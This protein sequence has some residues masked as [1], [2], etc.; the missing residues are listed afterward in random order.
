MVEYNPQE[1]EKRILD[2]WGKNK[3]FDKLMK[4]KKG[5]TFSF[6]DGPPTANNPMG[7][8]HAWGRTYKD[9][10]LR[11]KGMQGFETRRQP[12]FDCQ[13]LWVE[14]GVEK[15]LDFKTKKDIENYGIDKFTEKCKESVLK[16]VKTWIELSKK[17]G[18][19]MDWGNAYLTMSDT[20]IEY[21]WYFLK[22]CYEKGWLYKGLR[23]LPWCPRCQTSLSSHEVAS[24][25]KEKV[26][27]AIYVKF[28]I[29]DR[30]AE[31][32]LIYTTTPW[33]L[34]SN[35]AVAAHPDIEYVRIKVGEEV[36][37]LAK[38]LLEKAVLEKNYS[39]LQTMYGRELVEIQYE[40]P[41]KDLLPLQWNI[42]GKVVLSDKYV[43]AEEGT[44]LV[45]IAPGHGPE[46]YEIGKE[47]KLPVLSPLNEAGIFNEEVGFLKGKNAKEANE[48]VLEKLKERGLLY[49]EEKIKHSYPCCWRCDEE[50][51]YRIGEE[52]FISTQEIKPKLL[53]E[54]K[55]V[56]WYP[57]WA[58]KSMVDW[59]TNLK[60][61]N[62]SRKRYYGLPLPFWICEKCGLMDVIESK[63]ELKK[64]AIKG[65]KELK[66]LHRPW[67][68]NVVLKCSNCGG[69]M[70][71]IQET[72]DCWLDAGVVFY[73]TLKY[74]EDRKY[75]EKWFPAD[76]ITEMHEQVRLWFY[77]TLFVSV[78][79]EGKTPYKSVLAHG[80]VLDEKM[81]EM[82][83]SAGNVIWADEA[84]E[85]MGADVMRWMYCLQNPGQ[86]MP[87]GYTPAKD[88]ARTLNVLYNTIKFLQTYCEAN[89][90]KLKKPKSFD[91][92]SKWLLSRL[93]NLI[94]D[95]TN[96]LS[97]LKPHLATVKLEEFF[98]NDLSRWY[99][100][101]IREN[102]KP[103]VE[104]EY[105]ESILYTFYVSCL[106]TLKLLAPF[107]P[108]ITEDLWQSFFKKFEK[109][110][111]VHLC[112]WPKVEEK[113]I[114]ERLEKQMKIVKQI[115]E[116][117]NSLRHEK[118][119]KLK[120]LLPS[121][122]IDGNEEIKEAVRSLEEVIKELVN[123]KEVKIEEIEE[124]KE[125]ENG[126]IF[127]N[128]EINQEIKDEWL[129]SE[130]I[131]SVQDA[132][133]KI[134][135]EIK[136]KVELYLQENELFKKE[137][138]RIEKLTGS[139]VI[140][141]NILGKAFELEFEN[142]KYEFGIKA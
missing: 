9:L 55:K 102:I 67:I 29:K 61:W 142:K 126:K 84:L 73:S 133:K 85:K 42:I 32:L 1:I 113:L 104:S 115:V 45:H 89:Q 129:L 103:G 128:V 60:D 59:L 33:T 24:G 37:I 68:D 122:S 28:P 125:I 41:M 74:L 127:L 16:Y 121:L 15:E 109:E 86:P 137:K 112:D 99:G 140:F 135:L 114:D 63:E 82:H 50:L 134:G 69:E 110:E 70:K 3:I 136:D 139:K 78:T 123:V 8:H 10:Y 97:E 130:L 108:F 54:A 26:H 35:V 18:M 30:E 51:I 92:S 21:V 53:E 57:E 62:I 83:K 138:Q 116:V 6:I 106:T 117:A 56:K 72:G 91:V 7:V 132:R 64:K 80:M 98:L 20:N 11:F 107:I 81:R 49:R 5:K 27:P 58:L 75:W 43:S 101:I 17:L 100:H 46:D 76:F 13:G 119:I 77:A 4:S 141:G 88:V 36:L 95:V 105:K 66:E 131:R 25:Y 19:W 71:R 124:G 90:Y 52:W 22:K 87:F 65:F 96:N 94:K 44:G 38:D 12:G 31:Y 118:G 23:V 48:L 47:Y 2:F 111:S 120:Y 93:Q 14:V 34:A 79:L 39:V 40:N